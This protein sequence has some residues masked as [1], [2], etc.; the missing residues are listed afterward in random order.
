MS[1]KIKVT[2]TVVMT[3]VIDI[4]RYGGWTPEEAKRYEENLDQEAQ[5]D[6]V[7]NGLDLADDSSVA[8]KVEVIDA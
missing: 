4:S 6:A 7:I 1:T 5:F 2:R 3:Q 8:V